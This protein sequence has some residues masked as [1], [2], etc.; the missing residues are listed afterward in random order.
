MVT[1]IESNQTVSEIVFKIFLV[2]FCLQL[3]VL[4]MNTDLN[5]KTSSTQLEYDISDT[6]VSEDLPIDKEALNSVSQ[7]DIIL[8]FT[9]SSSTL[10]SLES[11]TICA[12]VM[13]DFDDK[14]RLARREKELMLSKRRFSPIGSEGM[15]TP[16]GADEHSSVVSD[17]SDPDSRATYNVNSPRRARIVRPVA[18]KVIHFFLVI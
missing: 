15:I 5:S 1:E 2:I 7:N 14:T 11:P 16:V 3:V 9:T 12:D 18:R 8:D 17:D 10:L 13:T 4:F 6:E